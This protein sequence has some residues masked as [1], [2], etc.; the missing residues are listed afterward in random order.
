[1]LLHSAHGHD[2]DCSPIHRER[3][4]KRGARGCLLCSRGAHAGHGAG[5]LGGAGRPAARAGRPDTPAYARSAGA[6]AGAALRLRDHGAVRSAAADHQPSHPSAARGGAGGRREAWRLV[7]LLGDRRGA[8]QSRTGEDPALAALVFFLPHSSTFF[9]ERSAVM[10][11][12]DPSVVSAE[13]PEAPEAPEAIAERV[14]ERYAAAARRA[15]SGEGGCCG[16]EGADTS[17]VTDHIYTAEEV[18]GLPE[19]AV[20]ASLGCGNP[21]ALIDLHEGETVLDLG[22]RGGIDVLLSPL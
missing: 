21:T 3:P 20:L 11:Q 1:M 18:A 5:A 17:A 13:A 8:A 12:A 22:S 2:A 16:T 7:L 14:R 10:S 4:R 19:A 9:D 6:A 15:Q